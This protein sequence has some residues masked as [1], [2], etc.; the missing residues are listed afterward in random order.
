MEIPLAL[1][2]LDESEIEAVCT[3]FRS[4][5]LTM[6]KQ[7]EN[8]ESSFA[9]KMRVKHAIMVNSGSSAN[10]LALE[11]LATKYAKVDF[12]S[13]SNYYVA[14]PAI[15]WPTSIW[16]IIQLGFRAL[17]IDTEPDS[18][19]ID[20]DLILEA[21]KKFGSA[22]IGAVLIHPL[23]KSL[24]LDKI[25]ELR[26]KH[27]MFIVED[28]C[29]SLGSGSL[30]KFAGTVG[31]V[32][33]FSF[34]Y[35]HHITTVEGGMIV[36]NSDSIANNIL[37][38][39][40]HGWTRNRLDKKEIESNYPNFN[41]DFLFVTSGYNFRP[42]EFQGVLGLSQ[43]SKLDGFI[44]KRIKIVSRVVDILKG[45]NFH[46]LGASKHTLEQINANDAVPEPV[47]HS[48]MAI[49]I[50]YSGSNLKMSEIHNFMNENGVATRP[51]LAG[52]F[53]KQPA[54]AHESITSFKDLPNSENIYLNSFMIGNHHNI[55][56]LQLEHLVKSLEKMTFLDEQRN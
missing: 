41:R 16:P 2:G 19:E 10:L 45:S 25:G 28:N 53:V 50:F 8:F 7:V 46:I 39:R 37:S 24:N 14:V 38:M 47:A 48:W 20:F 35:S 42:M 23:G 55:T 22:L 49:P 13:R 21:K 4:G 11:I 1:N 3:I 18:L 54:G 6:G 27:G 33:T 32:G 34:Y 12:S 52:N 29:E 43:L 17:I 5:N 9:R 30:K 40:A 56:D 31:D 26:E 36:T 44:D 15:L 51:I